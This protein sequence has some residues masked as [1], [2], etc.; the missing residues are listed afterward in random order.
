MIGFGRTFDATFRVRCPQPARIAV[1]IDGDGISPKEAGKVLDHL[2]TLGRVRTIRAYGNYTGKAAASWAG[3]VRNHGLVVRHMPS[4]VNGKNAAD[5]A[6][7][8][9]AIEML[10]TRKLDTFVLVGNDSDFAPLAR[11]IR[12][13]GKDVIGFGSAAAPPAFRSACTVY[14]DTWALGLPHEPALSLGPLWS[15]TPAD[16]EIMVAE[17]LAHLGA[18]TR[19]VVLAH[20]GQQLSERHPGFD[21]RIYSRRTLSELLRDLPSVRLGE[22]DGERTV[23]LSV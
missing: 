19:P 7:A 21:T 16:A 8:I 14:H 2:P 22:L 12:E 17:A 23:Q 15:R 6:L 13:E 3:L 1:F 9:D 11:R 5:I 10:L 20:L 18:D 4:L